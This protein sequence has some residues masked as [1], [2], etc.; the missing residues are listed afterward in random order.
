MPSKGVLAQQNEELRAEVKSKRAAFEA[1]DLSVDEF[2]SFMDKA[3]KENEKLAIAQKTYQRALGFTGAGS[4]EPDGEPPKAEPQVMLKQYQDGFAKIKAAANTNSRH[5]AEVNFEFGL[6]SF[7]DEAR[8][9]AQ[10][11]TGLSGES[12]SGTTTPSALAGG[13]YF[14]GGTAGPF[15]QPEFLPGIVDLRFYK[16]VIAELIPSYAADSPVITYVRESTWTNNAAATWEGQTKPTSTHSFTRYTEQ[17]GKIANLERTTDE[18]IQDAPFV[19]SLIQKRLVDGVIRKEEV[20]ILAGSGM[21]GVNGL[22][23]RTGG[24][25]APQTVTAVTNLVVPAAGTPGLGSSTDT[26]ASVTPGRAIIGVGTGVAPTGSAIAEGIFDAIVD[27]RV[28][29]FF[30]PDAVVMN[31]LDFS[32]IRK[33]KDNNLQYY[34]GG[35]FGGNYGY[36]NQEQPLPT[37][38]TTAYLWDKKVVLTPA[39]PQ[40]FILVGDFADYNYVV[41]RGG[42]RVD[43]TNTNG[44]DFEQNLWTARGEERVG[45]VVERPELFELIQL[46]NG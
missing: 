16:N 40:G 46:K 6:K 30:E 11:V 42:L 22:L 36:P 23:N 19:W 21:P 14:L 35:F 44:T 17:I 4:P 33:A 3:E 18:L 7:E 12:S 8:M 41:R 15:I 39:M 10:G 38:T 25:T 20:E 32:T 27:L 37:A 5:R 31:P 24:F 43:V 13:T 2:T 45:L 1:G 26:V 9:K 28:K 29:T 34:G